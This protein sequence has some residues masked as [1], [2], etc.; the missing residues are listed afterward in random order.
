M[1]F[2]SY[3]FKNSVKRLNHNMFLSRDQH[4]CSWSILQAK[5]TWII[6]HPSKIQKIVDVFRHTSVE[7][8]VELNIIL[9]EIIYLNKRQLRV[10]KIGLNTFQH[11]RSRHRQ[12]SKKEEQT[13]VCKCS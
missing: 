6:W 11:K 13:Y 5:K 7:Y 12:Q 3:I 1:N 10:I 2:T 8:E 4:F 9:Q